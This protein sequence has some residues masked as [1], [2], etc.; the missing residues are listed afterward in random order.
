[1]Q[2]LHHIIA[3]YYELLNYK[4]YVARLTLRRI[5][6]YSANKDFS[7]IFIRYLQHYCSGRIRPQGITWSHMANIT[8]ATGSGR[9]N[10]KEKETDDVA[11]TINH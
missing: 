7:F 2:T 5:P 4:Y 6:A 11:L 10:E 8:T 1:M 9:K 3:K